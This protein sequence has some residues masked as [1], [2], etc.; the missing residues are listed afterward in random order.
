[1]TTTGIPE[2]D[3]LRR[4][5][6]RMTGVPATFLLGI[7]KMIDRSKSMVPGEPIFIQMKIRTGDED[8]VDALYLTD[9]STTLDI[10]QA[11]RFNTLRGALATVDR[12]K[13]LRRGDVLEVEAR[14]A[15]DVTVHNP[16]TIA[17]N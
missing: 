9:W 8:V 12:V 1:M 3:K 17:V 10:T 7:P 2:I 6:N 13:K 4:A 15:C 11:K 16:N 5:P 14:T